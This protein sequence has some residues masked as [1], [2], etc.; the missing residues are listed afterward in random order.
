MTK[1]LAEATANLVEH[2]AIQQATTGNIE[3]ARELIEAVRIA[4]DEATA[5][6]NAA[7]RTL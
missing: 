6:I 4:C 2:L 7:A 3:Q 5:T 1:T